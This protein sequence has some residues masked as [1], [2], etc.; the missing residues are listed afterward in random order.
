MRMKMM[1]FRQIERSNNTPH[2]TRPIVIL[3]LLALLLVVLLAVGCRGEVEE[4]PTTRTATPTTSLRLTAYATRTFAA[5]TPTPLGV[6][7]T[8][9]PSP[10]PTPQVHVIALNQTLISIA[11]LYGVSLEALQNANPEI[12][13]WALVVGQELLIPWQEPLEDGQNPTPTP[14]PVTLSPARCFEEASGG[15]WCLWSAFNP[16]DSGT[17][18][19]LVEIALQ[20]ASS[21]Q[22][23]SQ[24]MTAPLNIAAAGARVPMGAFFSAQQLSEAEFSPPYQTVLTLRQALPFTE[25]SARYLPITLRQQQIDI[26]P[27][28]LSAEITGRLVLKSEATASAAAIWAAAALYNEADELIGFRRWESEQPLAP[29]ESLPFAMSVFSLSGERIQ[30]V[31]ILLEARP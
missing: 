2:S 17:E 11:N 30:R 26:Q 22:R 31:E 12:N 18:N 8:P 15:A 21:N 29:D 28:G 23:L 5:A 19:I 14:Q 16:P 3:G 10:T 13:P 20:S 4:S 24:V 27:D 6:T 25:P 9:I 1:K 7:T